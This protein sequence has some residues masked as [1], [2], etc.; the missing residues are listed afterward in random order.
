MGN[1]MPI[2][3]LFYEFNPQGRSDNDLHNKEREEIVIDILSGKD[4]EDNSKEFEHIKASLL[5]EFEKIGVSDIVTVKKRGGLQNHQDFIIIFKNND[6]SEELKIEFKTTQTSNMSAENMQTQLYLKDANFLFGVESDADY[7]NEFY[8]NELDAILKH[9]GLKTEISKKDYIKLQGFYYDKK[10]LP[11]FLINLKEQVD[12]EKK[13]LGKGR[14]NHNFSNI[15]AIISTSSFLNGKKLNV[16]KVEK[17]INKKRF[18]EKDYILLWNI[19]NKKFSLKK[20]TPIKIIRT[21]FKYGSR[22]HNFGK[23]NGYRLF[24]ERGDEFELRL[25]WKNRPGIHG[26]AWQIS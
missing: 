26:P 11:K 22:P 10:K 5:S 3:R 13:K 19:K 21:E 7:I 16:K 2:K 15:R 17:E 20:T 25:R 8:D 6:K 24:L 1:N 23:I 4:F 14:A 12:K 9:Y 18:E